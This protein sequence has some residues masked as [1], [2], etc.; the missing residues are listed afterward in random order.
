M[1]SLNVIA[2]IIRIMKVKPEII[3][4]LSNRFG[5]VLPRE[6]RVLAMQ[7]QQAVYDNVA[8]FGTAVGRESIGIANLYRQSVEFLL[9]RQNLRGRYLAEDGT[10]LRFVLQT[11]LGASS[12]SGSERTGGQTEPIRRE[13]R[14]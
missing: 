5:K 14:R 1:M 6:I 13:R 9:V 11:V 10:V 8:E 3:L 12:E 4:Y 7:P 2:F